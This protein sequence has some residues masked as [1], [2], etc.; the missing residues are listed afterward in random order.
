MKKKEEKETSIWSKA[1]CEWA[2]R[3]AWRRSDSERF[4][5]LARLAES[6]LARLAECYLAR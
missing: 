6:Y 4:D 5:S 3:G 2:R 1:V